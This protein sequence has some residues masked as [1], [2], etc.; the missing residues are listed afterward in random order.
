MPPNKPSKEVKTVSAFVK[1]MDGISV[2]DDM[3]LSKR[4]QMTSQDFAHQFDTTRMR[5]TSLQ[6]NCMIS[7]NSREWKTISFFAI[8]A[9]IQAKQ[10]PNITAMASAVKPSKQMKATDSK[11]L[12]KWINIVLS[13]LDALHPHVIKWSN[14]FANDCGNNV[15][16]GVDTM[17]CLFHQILV[18]HRTKPGKLTRKKALYSKKLYGPALRYKVAISLLSSDVVWISGPW[19]PDDWNDLS[20]FQQ[21]L[22]HELEEGECMEADD[23]YRSESDHTVCLSS[24]ELIGD[25]EQQAKFF[26]DKYQTNIEANVKAKSTHPIPNLPYLSQPSV[27]TATQCGSATQHRLPKHG[28][29]D[30]DLNPTS[31]CANHQN[32][33]R[34]QASFLVFEPCFPLLTVFISG[35]R[36]N[37]Q[38]LT[39][40]YVNE[41]SS[42]FFLYFLAM[43]VDIRVRSNFC[44]N[45]IQSNDRRAFQ[46][47]CSFLYHY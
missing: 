1:Q 18:P 8:P 3:R 31:N 23:I 45:D 6:H 5:M 43:T 15:L 11:T 35:L 34:H 14:H 13:T 9:I 10:Y 27:D 24:A 40:E 26:C 39:A 4:L 47:Y 12:R 37:R 20:I 46:P 30:G 16:A 42:S 17:D 25:E 28:I 7:Y 33:A 2:K 38:P 19:L 22:M 44:L 32:E 36:L 41:G 21:G 29:E